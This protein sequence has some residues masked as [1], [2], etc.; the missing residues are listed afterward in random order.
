M[1]LIIENQGSHRCALEGSTLEAFTQK[2]FS[3]LINDSHTRQNDY[4]L[5]RVVCEE[6]EGKEEADKKGIKVYQCYDAKQLC[7]YVFEMV[8]S[9]EER[10]VQIKNFRDPVN[11]KKINELYFFRLR[12]DSDSPMRAEY[13]GSHQDFLESQS[14]R[15]KL[16][17]NE[18]A[19]DAL[20]VNFKQ[21][22][23]KRIPFLTKKQLW[24]LLMVVLSALFICTLLVVALERRR[25]HRVR[26]VTRTVNA[27]RKI[28]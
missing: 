15:A 22:K 27:T 14:F 8:I 10:K 28:Q 25:M 9:A 6:Q 1:V 13:A 7:K 18:D 2:T 20:S 24:T 12:H 16:F 4:Y 23:M 5:A 19:L 11:Q 3:S 17:A 21:N 26:T